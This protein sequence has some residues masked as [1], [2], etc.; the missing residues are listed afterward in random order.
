MEN[1]TNDYFIASYLEEIGKRSP[2]SFN[3]NRLIIR[4]LTKYVEKPFQNISM[5][6][7]QNYLI[8]VID[9]KDIKKSTKNTKR[10]MLK[11]F[12]NYIVRIL[13]SYKIEYHNPVPSKKLYRFSTNLDDIEYVEDIELNILTI[14]QIKKILNYCK[15][16]LSLRDFI[17]VGLAVCTGMRI[18]EDRTVLRKD[19][20]LKE[21]N[22]Q[23]GF[24]LGAR[25]TTLH[26]GKG[27][28]FFFPPSFAKYVQEY[29]ESCDKCDKWLFPGYCGNHL[30]RSA[31]QDMVSTIRKGVDFHFTWHDFRRTLI[32]ELSKMGCSLEIRELLLNHAPS[33]VESKSY[34]KL[35]IKEKQ[36][37]YLQYFPYSSISY[38][39]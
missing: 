6:D 27:L 4:E 21:Y 22:L 38:F 33:S 11:A 18:S 7:M 23:T 34:L 9:K 12:F 2:G 20:N 37:Y 39:K 24:I 14:D 28:L 35:S 36:S 3:N 30:S 32:T 25:K 31:T 10:Y 1:L 8:N 17:L 19:I 5:V 15:N 16:K 13:L 29:I 26:T